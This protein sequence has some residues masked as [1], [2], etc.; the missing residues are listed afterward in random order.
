MRDKKVHVPVNTTKASVLQDLEYFGFCEIQDDAID[1]CS[2]NIA[3]RNKHLFNIENEMETLTK[4]YRGKILALENEEAKLTLNYRGEY[5]ARVC[6]KKYI[7]RAAKKGG[8]I[9]NISDLPK[10]ESFGLQGCMVSLLNPYLRKYGL[11]V[12]TSVMHS[13]ESI[14]VRLQ[15]LKID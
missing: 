13:S 14:Q 1:V 2:A 12:I 4:S 8:V 15:E 5:L 3:V 7:T 10:G 9:I 6:F 11:S